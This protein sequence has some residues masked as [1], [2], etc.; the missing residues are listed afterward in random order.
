MIRIAS[1]FALLSLSSVLY[2]QKV[3]NR[4]VYGSNTAIGEGRWRIHFDAQYRDHQLLGDL[5]Q[6]IIR[7]GIQYLHLPSR[8]SYTIGYAYFVFQD[9]G[10]PNNTIFENRIWQDIDLRQAVSRVQIRHRYRFEERFIENRPFSFRMRYS[11]MLDIPLN[12]PTIEANTWYLSFFNEVFINHRVSSFD[13]VFDRDWLFGGFGYRL[14]EKMALQFGYM[15]Q[16][17]ERGSKPQFILS[18]NHNLHI[19][20]TE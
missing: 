12:K 4:L 14:N 10:E 13:P 1:F 9:M 19:G 18:F 5:D 15:N 11:L 20:K 3:G 7:P 2:A 17:T 6:L 8:S 16:F